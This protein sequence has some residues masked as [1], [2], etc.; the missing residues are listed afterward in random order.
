VDG[1]IY[2]HLIHQGKGGSQTIT[3]IHG[4]TDLEFFASV[5]ETSCDYSGTDSIGEIL[6]GFIRLYG[7]LVSTIIFLD[8]RS[9]STDS[10]RYSVCCGSVKIGSSC[11]DSPLPAEEIEKALSGISYTLLKEGKIY[12]CL[13]RRYDHVP[14]IKSDL[15][16]ESSI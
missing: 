8:S 15:S 12:Y 16:G 3:Y 10:Q 4:T 2:H 5:E 9:S 11:P 6:S 13:F 7:S 1:I 14:G